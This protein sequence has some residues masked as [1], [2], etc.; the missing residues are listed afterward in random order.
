MLDPGGGPA[1]TTVDAMRWPN[2]PPSTWA[3][4]PTLATHHPSMPADTDTDSL[5]RAEPG[6]QP[7]RAR[8]LAW[9]GSWVGLGSGWAP[10][11][12][13]SPRAAR[14]VKGVTS[15]IAKRTL[16]PNPGWRVVA[17]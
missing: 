17:S 13:S 10:Q 8:P 11:S 3:S 1:I 16:A 14:A 9:P 6:E 4:L 7:L 12:M 2:L 5:P 15:A